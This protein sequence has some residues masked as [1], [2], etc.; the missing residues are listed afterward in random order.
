MGGP[1]DSKEE[2]DDICKWLRLIVYAV[3]QEIKAID[4]L[5]RA[6]ARI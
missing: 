4:T 2:V 6:G 1:K 3:K 5:S